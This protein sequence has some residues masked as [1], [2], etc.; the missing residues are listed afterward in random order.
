[1][2]VLDSDV[3]IDIIDQREPAFSFVAK[4]QASGQVIGT[5]SI[6]AA[7][8]LRGVAPRSR[9]A[10][11]VARVLAALQEVPFGPVASRRFGTIMHAIDRAGASLPVVDGLIAAATIESG[12]RLLTCNVRDFGRVAGL[13]VIAPD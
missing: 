7:E 5:T 3:L 8:V 4:L 6:N 1:M 11:R 12:G 10:E 13:D 2:I 9:A